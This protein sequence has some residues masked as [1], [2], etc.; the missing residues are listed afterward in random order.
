M[1]SGARRPLP[2]PDAAC[3]REEQV[4]LVLE[5][6]WLAAALPLAAGAGAVEWWEADGA[7]RAIERLKG[8]G[9][10]ESTGRGGW[11]LRPAA[12]AAATEAVTA[13]WRREGVLVAV[14]PGRAWRRQEPAAAV[15][16][17]A[18]LL[19]AVDGTRA[20]ARRR[21]SSAAV[22]AARRAVA[23]IEREWGAAGGREVVSAAHDE[24]HPALAVWEGWEPDVAAW[25]GLAAD[26]G[27]FA[28][29]D[30]PAGAVWTVPAGAL[31]EWF[32]ASPGGRW[33]RLAHAFRRMAD[34]H[35]V[36]RVL[37]WPE[38][39]EAVVPGRLLA[40]LAQRDQR[41]AALAAYAITAV[42]GGAF[43]LGL[44]A[45]A[46]APG[47]GE[48]GIAVR[49]LPEG[50]RLLSGEGADP[51]PL[52]P[53]SVRVT[54]DFRVYAPA[55]DDPE[56]AFWLARFADLEGVDGL[57][58]HHLTRWR[59]T[60]ACQAGYAPDDAL[61]FLTDGGDGSMPPNVAFTLEHDWSGI[62]AA[63]PAMARVEAALLLRL[64]DEATAARLRALRAVRSAVAEEITPTVWRLHPLDG[65]AL[66]RLRDR[67]AEAGTMLALAPEAVR[68]PEE[69]T[70]G[71][72]SA[73]PPDRAGARPSA[74]YAEGGGLPVHLDGEPVRLPWPG[75][76]DGGGG[77]ATPWRLEVPGR[78]PLPARLPPRPPPQAWR[79]LARSLAPGHRLLVATRQEGILRVAVEW[80]DRNGL[81]G[82][83]EDG[84]LH[85]WETSEIL[86]LCEPGQVDVTGARR[87]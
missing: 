7:E 69:G 67:V 41:Y 80:A 72:R 86:G 85:V 70:G 53:A 39:G 45:V 4:G 66:G 73:R 75:P 68:P 76:F 58:V 48:D 59:W 78:A 8:A 49:L 42:V 12:A 87:Y 6:L 31:E 9:W 77:A 56:R 24:R 61:A 52:A 51:P 17:M 22:A 37:L 36:S 29:A 65:R 16:A 20:T 50:R 38:E 30:D 23:P 74:P 40:W 25:V 84:V 43:R 10:A 71:K 34:V 5:R 44:A 35:A 13:T 55:A 79:R 14:D 15:A 21:L 54:G 64:P 60:D 63:G 18:R 32:A 3:L 2:P 28:L 62:D 82:R 26:L 83:G 46:P 11:R 33:A 19:A 1:A 47:G 57:A 27:L 81:A